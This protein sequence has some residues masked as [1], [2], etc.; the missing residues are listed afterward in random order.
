MFSRTFCG[1]TTRLRCLVQ[2]RDERIALLVLKIK[3]LERAK[4]TAL[5]RKRKKERE[6]KQA[7]R[8]KNRLNES[9][10]SLSKIKKPGRHVKNAIK[11][12]AAKKKR[13]QKAKE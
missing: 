5:E 8:K 7:A 13:E 10:T 3:S 1:E 12:L 9:L 2:K 11:V 4:T 6:R